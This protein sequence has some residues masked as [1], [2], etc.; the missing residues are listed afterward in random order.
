ML[1][2]Y[3]LTDSSPRKTNWV[4]GFIVVVSWSWGQKVLCTDSTA[5]FTER[6][7]VWQILWSWLFGIFL[8]RFYLSRSRHLAVLWGWCRLL[9]VNNLSALLIWTHDKRFPY[10]LVSSTSTRPPLHFQ[11]LPARLVQLSTNGRRF[12]WT[13]L[14]VV[15]IN[16][17]R[18]K[19]LENWP[20]RPLRTCFSTV[21]CLLR[22]GRHFFFVL[23]LV[24]RYVL[25]RLSDD[26]LLLFSYFFVIKIRIIFRH[27]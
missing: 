4:V 22:H 9:K 23:I 2:K 26:F 17:Q 3:V 20:L 25:F 13:C 1:E 8:F 10:C 14:T 19:R 18:R 24:L 6:P 15:T 11:T 12:S 16:R 27:I 21:F 7:T 5:L